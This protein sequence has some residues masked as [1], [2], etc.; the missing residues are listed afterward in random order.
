MA[1]ARLSSQADK[2]YGAAEV[3]VG[4]LSVLVY[5]A[6]E[7][8][9]PPILDSEGQ[10]LAGTFAMA[11]VAWFDLR[12]HLTREVRDKARHV[13]LPGSPSIKFG[14]FRANLTVIELVVNELGHY[15][16]NSLYQDRGCP[17]DP[18]KDRIWKETE[19]EAARQSKNKSWR[20]NAHYE[21]SLKRETRSVIFNR[22]GLK[23]LGDAWDLMAKEWNKRES[24]ET[25][26]RFAR[27]R[28]EDFDEIEIQ[29][30]REAHAVLAGPHARAK[31]RKVQRQWLGG[32]LLCL[33]K[34]PDWSD[35]AI[36]REAGIDKSQLTRCIEYRTAANLF[37]TGGRTIAPSAT[38]THP[39]QKASRQSAE[40]EDDDDRLNREM[41]EKLK[42]NATRNATPKARAKNAQ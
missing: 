9:P 16:Q 27:L 40:E 28:T 36:A 19:A 14:M 25:E 37:R 10:R 1:R 7:N 42:R 33:R 29:L 5:H 18:D 21:T 34:H 32:A 41:D 39:N 38:T 15:M 22:L 11:F 24:A 35:A 13:Y 6:R 4:H 8:P 30:Y 12:G 26:A 3:F 23:N 17:F 20:F 2:A 31:A